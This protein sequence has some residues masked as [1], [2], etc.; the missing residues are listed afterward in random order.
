MEYKDYYKTLGV[1]KDASQ[2]EIKKAY[3]KLAV[4]YHPDKNQGDK[5][6]EAMF[7]EVSEAYQV[8]NNP[9]KRKQYDELGANWEQYQHAGFDP[10][11]FSERRGPTGSQKYYH[12]QGDPSEIF[13]GSG[14]SDFFEAF[15]G[16]ASAGGRDPFSRPFR[17]SFQ[18][19]DQDIPGS[20][21][22]GDILITLEEAFKGTERLIDLGNQKI[23]VKIKPGAYDGLKLRVKGKG[24]KGATGKAGNLILTVRVSKHPVYERKENDLYM[25]LPVD[26]FTALL[27]DKK[28]LATLS[29]KVSISIPEGA[30]NGQQ[31]RLRQKGLPIYGKSGYGDLYVRIKVKLPDRL[32]PEQKK[33][34][35]KLKDSFSK[36]YA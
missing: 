24:H 29:G 19:F 33:L 5:N 34:V 35:E 32:S 6:A 9:E 22:T 12:F 26:L 28:E 16:G 14:F 10:S 18:G 1:D 17:D 15:F 13:G 30:Q 21:L 36:R 7:K 3:R 2:Q 31:L 20:N 8:L 11:A 4:K 25:E 23:R 27:G